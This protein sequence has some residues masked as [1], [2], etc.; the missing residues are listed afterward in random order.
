MSGVFEQDWLC[1]TVR[2]CPQYCEAGAPGS[3]TSSPDQ[4]MSARVAIEGVDLYGLKMAYYPVDEKDYRDGATAIDPLFGEH[5]LETIDR[6]FWFMGYV[7]QLPPN[8]R[9]Y[10]LQGIWGE[11]VVQLYV[12]T[13]AFLYF[14]T[15]GGADRNTPEIHDKMPPRIG[16]VVYIPNNDTLY[17]IVDVKN[18][19]EAFGLKP[20]YKTITMRVYK[21]SKRT[22]S[23]DPSIPADDVIRKYSPSEIP[24]DRPTNDSLKLPMNRAEDLPE[25]IPD[26]TKVDLFDWE[27]KEKR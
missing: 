17:E 7:S 8:V 18:W 14:S 15:Y 10:Q 3:P 11:D 1:S 13:E 4:A 19:E 2:P 5:Q 6:C 16:D 12:A 9:T 26:D 21:D 24:A 22:V 25:R 20:R 27:W 23:D